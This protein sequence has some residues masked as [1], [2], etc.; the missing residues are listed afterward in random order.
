[1]ISEDIKYSFN[2]IETALIAFVGNLELQ[3]QQIMPNL[4]TFVL[5]T[6]DFS[7]FINKKFIET[8][9]KEIYEKTPRFVIGID[10]IQYLTEQNTNPYNKYTYIFQNK[11]YICVGRRIAIS[12]PVNTDFISP[13][14]IMGFQNFE[15]MSTIVSKENAYTYNFLG[16]TLEG[17]YVFNGTNMEKP[18]MDINAGTRNVSIRT[19]FE[20]QLQLII[21]RIDSIK[22]LSESEYKEINFNLK[23]N[24][25]PTYQEEIKFL[26]NNLDINNDE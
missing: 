8:S 20:L 16:N 17:C 24:P 10:D 11:Y 7:Y 14:L 19:T 12:L 9:N 15:I 21:P 3:L 13:N 1:M 26:M 25:N 23:V 5:Q 2:Q 22:L 6:G 4:P 18:T